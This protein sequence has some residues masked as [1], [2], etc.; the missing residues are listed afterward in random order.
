MISPHPFGY[1]KWLAVG[2]PD[3]AL[4]GDHPV[5]PYTIRIGPK[6]FYPSSNGGGTE[7]V[8]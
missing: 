6:E 3:S 5:L 7:Y 1:Q 4:L 2:G 8:A